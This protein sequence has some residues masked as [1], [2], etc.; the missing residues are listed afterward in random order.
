M[1]KLIKELLNNFK[2]IKVLLKKKTKIKNNYK[3]YLI[4]NDI[5][6]KANIFFSLSNDTQFLIILYNI[7]INYFK[8]NI[9]NLNSYKTCLLNNLFNH[10]FHSF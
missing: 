6:F 4:I 9:N 8:N 5:Y 10:F 7:F 3:L 2:I 1:N